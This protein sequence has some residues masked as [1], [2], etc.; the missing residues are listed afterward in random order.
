MEKMSKMSFEEWKK[1][2]LKDKEDEE[3][4]NMSEEELRQTY[5]MIQKVIKMRKGN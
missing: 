1:M 2:A 3:I 4:Q 5:N